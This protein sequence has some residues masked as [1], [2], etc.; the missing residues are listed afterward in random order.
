M[1]MNKEIITSSIT[2]DSYTRIK[3]KSGLEILVWEMPGFSSAEA[4]FGTRYG[5]INTR[6]RTLGESNYTTVPE[7][8]AHFLE[9]KLFENEE[10][11]AFAQY[12]RTGASAN[13]YT[14]FD[15]TCYLFSCTQNFNESL[16]I[17]LSFV[18]E[19][20]FTEETAASTTCLSVCITSI[21]SRSTLPVQLKA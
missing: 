5:S 20:Y 21:R 8:I 16:K 11:D 2:G 12:A 10:C 1:T 3:H 15:K 4:L 13:A 18:Q 9:H 17:L 14:S 6:F 19:P 7:G